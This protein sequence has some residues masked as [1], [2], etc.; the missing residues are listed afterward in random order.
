[1]AGKLQKRQEQMYSLVVF[2]LVVFRSLR[3]FSKDKDFWSY[4]C[5][6][7]GSLSQTKKQRPM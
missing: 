1:M 6:S 2:S 5:I 3:G 7:A 4:I